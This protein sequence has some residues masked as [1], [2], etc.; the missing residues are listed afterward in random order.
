MASD[1]LSNFEPLSN[2][3]PQQLA[4]MALLLFGVLFA[5]Q[6]ASLW[7]AYEQPTDES[8]PLTRTILLFTPPSIL[9]CKPLRIWGPC[10]H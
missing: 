3:T 5:E 6:S 10:L 7:Y 8:V 1:R 9:S 4:T 2:R